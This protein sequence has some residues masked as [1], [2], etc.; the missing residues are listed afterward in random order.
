MK[1]AKKL[2][3]AL[4]L[5]ALALPH[6]AAVAEKRKQTNARPELP[7]WDSSYSD[8]AC[9]ISHGYVKVLGISEPMKTEQGAREAAMTDARN[10]LV[11][12]LA[13]LSYYLSQIF[14]KDFVGKG[15]IISSNEN[16]ETAFMITMTM[17]R[18]NQIVVSDIMMC[19]CDTLI[20]DTKNGVKTGML[21][22][23]YVAKIRIESAFHDEVKN[24]FQNT[25]MFLEKMD[26]Y[27][28][29]EA[30]KERQQKS[31]GQ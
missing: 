27:L 21:I 24:L 20:S 19:E 25:Q 3:V 15:E 18:F 31:N 7:C 9:M 6:T 17:P 13:Y 5:L 30:E 11:K 1:P 16:R 23:Y 2:I 29:E 14:G 10:K 12:H 28:A 8:S 4:I 22:G 26:K